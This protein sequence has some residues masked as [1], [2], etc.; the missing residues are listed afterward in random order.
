[1][2]PYNMRLRK[3][4][5]TAAAA[6]TLSACQTQRQIVYFQDLEPEAST[7]VVAPQAIRFHAAD[8]L[9][10]VVN[11]QDYRLT[12]LFNLVTPTRRLGNRN[13]VNNNSNNQVAYYT[14]DAEG[15]IEFPVL[16]TLHIE[17]MTREEVTRYVHDEIVNRDLAK[18]PVVT[19]EYGNLY[20]T[21]L[22]EVTKPGRYSIDKD[23]VTVLDVLSQAGDLGIQGRRDRVWVYRQE[24]DQRR[25]YQLNLCSAEQV[26]ASPVYYLQQDDQVYVEPNNIRARQSTVNGNTVRSTS[27]WFSVASLLTTL[28]VIIF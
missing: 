22:G 19:V 13:G 9:S 7:A 26:T 4:L 2:K 3:A 23:R 25:A 1:M 27:F 11:C 21:V 20:V 15:N 12:E 5:L 18:D 14:V 24:G 10:I 8:Q 16:G 17:G 6:L 28:A